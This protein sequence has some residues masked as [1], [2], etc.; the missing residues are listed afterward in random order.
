MSVTESMRDVGDRMGW[1]A[2]TRLTVALR[3]VEYQADESAFLDF[4]ETVAEEETRAA[5][6][7]PPDQA[8][9][10]EAGLG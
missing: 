4:L 1:D 8:S 5:P 10:E 2:T 9:A 6:P 3:Y 7:A